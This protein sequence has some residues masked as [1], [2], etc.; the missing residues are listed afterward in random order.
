MDRLVP[1]ELKAGIRTALAD[2]T[3][4]LNSPKHM[5]T[6]HLYKAVA[7]DRISLFSDEYLYAVALFSLKR[8]MKYIYT[9]EYQRESN[10][11]TYLQNLTPD[12]YTDEEYVFEEECYFRVCLKRRDGQDITLPDAKR[13]SEALRYEA[14][15]EEKNIKQ[16]FKEE[17]KKTVQDILH[18]RKDFLAFCVLTDTHY[19]VNGTWEDTA[20][21]IQAIHEQVHFDE[22][23]HLGDVTDGIT[24]AKV[25]SDYAKAVLRDL[26]SCNIPVRMVLGNH[27]SNYFRNNSEKF[28]IE[29]Q[30]KLYLNDGNELTAPYYYV[31]YPKHNLRCLFLH[32][33]DYEAPI[34]YGFSDKEVEWVRET[35]ESMKDGGKVLV[36]S[37]D[38]PFAELD[39]WSH[40]IRNGE[41]MMDVLEE[42]NSKDKFHI[43]GYF[44]G[45]IHADSIYEN[46]SFPLVSIAC[47]KCECFAGMKPEGAIAPKRCPN[48][49][50][51]DLWDT[52]ILDIEKEKIHMVRFGAG[53]DRVV[54][55]SKKESIRKQLLEEKRRNRKTKVWA[56]RGASAYAPENTLPAFALAVG[57]GSDGIELDVQLTKDGVPVV[58]HDEAINRVS[59]GMGNVWDYTLE[60]IKSFN[61]NMQ[62]PAYGKV[63]I[64]TLE[65][66][67]NLLQDEE[68][69][70]N[71]ELKN[72]IYF[73]EGLEEKVLKLA[74]KYKMEDRIVYSSFNHSSMIHLKKLQDDVKVAFLYG[75][76]FI[77]IAGYARKNGAY[78][79]HPEIANIK[80]PRFLEECREKDVR[81][82][83]WNV[84]E[85]ADIKRMA[86]AR[87]DA[88]ITNYPDR[89]GQIVES[90]SNGK[91]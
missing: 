85:R 40:S 10:W 42:F 82:H 80:Y 44:Y 88:V 3:L 53:E 71:L 12:S 21:N 55:C 81:V 8:D 78:A 79:I 57:L 27:D 37:H 59:D 4:V 2:G 52:V 34:R 41:R 74:L 70:V 91:R 83:V 48:T 19:T 45:H 24:S 64:P 39:Y 67:Y 50:T 73:Y 9:Y 7:G 75:D 28:T 89:A 6:E 11:T 56:H 29:E 61:F 49:V 68:V 31:D 43:L 77:D 18:L 17:I 35:L 32:S 86:E 87:V 84:N 38:A 69:T 90:F 62:F 36:F 76:G 15:K 58:I 66:V 46:C 72:H 22:I 23:I 54:D 60:E 25:T 1:V 13:G 33:F 16:C 5:A 51:Q 30:M 26:R 65:E 47:A 63:E 20:F 14:A